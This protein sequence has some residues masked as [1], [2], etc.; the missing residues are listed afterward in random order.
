MDGKNSVTTQK[1]AKESGNTQVDAK[2][3]INTQM[4]KNSVTTQTAKDTVTTHGWQELRHQ[5]NECQGNNQHQGVS[6]HSDIQ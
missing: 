3:P 4:Y 1:N 5:P 6:Y 2:N